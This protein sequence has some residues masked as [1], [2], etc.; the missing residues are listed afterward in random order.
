MER[1]KKAVGGDELETLRRYWV[2]L[3]HLMTHL[4]IRMSQKVGDSLRG[5]KTG[6]ER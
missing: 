1:L 6:G 3:K 5:C 4:K 2:S